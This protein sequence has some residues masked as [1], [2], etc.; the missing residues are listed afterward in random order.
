IFI[1]AAL[2]ALTVYLA[3]RRIEWRAP[4]ASL[5]GI[6]AG[7]VINPYFPKNLHLLYEHVLMKATAGSGY[8]VDVGIE[9]YPYDAWDLVRLSAL[10]FVIFI[11]GLAAFEYRRRRDLKPLYFLFVALLLLLMA[12]KSRRFVEYWPPF[13][14]LF[15]AFTISPRLAEF[16]RSWFAGASVSNLYLR[17]IRWLAGLAQMITNSGRWAQAVFTDLHIFG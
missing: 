10:A 3:E 9:W 12:F 5:I 15:A 1:F 16:D 14:V 2:Y 4:L 11:A 17:F 7:L 6:L 8:A 13:A